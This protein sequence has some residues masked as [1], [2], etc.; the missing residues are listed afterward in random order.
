MAVDTS[1]VIFLWPYIFWDSVLLPCPFQTREFLFIPFSD[2]VD[3]L[4]PF[5]KYEVS[6]FESCEIIYEIIFCFPFLLFLTNLIVQ[7]RFLR[8]FEEY[9]KCQVVLIDL[10]A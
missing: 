4:F 8:Q 9:E 1:L 2:H 7:S 5:K 3:Y 10:V 6:F